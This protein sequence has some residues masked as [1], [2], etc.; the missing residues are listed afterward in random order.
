MSTM[1]KKRISTREL[2]MT[3]LFVTLITVGAFIR[4]PLPNCPFT[5]QIL[6]TTL[7]GI[8]L[9]SRLGAVSVGIYIILGLIGVPVFT[10]GGGPGYILQP[11]FGYLVG[12]MVGAYVV[13]RFSEASPNH[14]F[15]QLLIGS[16]LNLLVVYGF[17]MVYLYM[18]MNVYLATPI[19][20][21]P[22]VVSCFLIP[23]GPDIFLCTVAA[24]LGRR[25]IAQL[26]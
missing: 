12:F 13:G 25:I 24:M 26:R 2:T 22:V 16:I 10:S 8:I 14:S 9:G 19:G 7:A 23:V 21:W 15:K 1:S 11:T 6:F 5:L 18:I 4:I 3:A 20:W 17:G